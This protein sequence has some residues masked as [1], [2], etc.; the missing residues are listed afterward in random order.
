MIFRVTSLGFLALFGPSWTSA[1]LSN[2]G[3]VQFNT[4]CDHAEKK[5]GDAANDCYSAYKPHIPY[6]HVTNKKTSNELLIYDTSFMGKDITGADA[7]L[8]GKFH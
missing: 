6:V 1:E 3:F 2:C 5:H 8:E 4:N 7:D